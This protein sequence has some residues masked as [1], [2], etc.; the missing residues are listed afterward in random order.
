MEWLVWFFNLLDPHI[1]R[2]KFFL[3][4][5]FEVIWC[6]ENTV[7]GTHEERE[8]CEDTQE[9]PDREP[10]EDVEDQCGENRN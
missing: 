7:N 6:A 9:T 4:E 3:N 2:V 10:E 1:K 5:I 8:E